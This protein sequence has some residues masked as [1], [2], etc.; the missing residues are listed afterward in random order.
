MIRNAFTMQ[1][2]K[3]KEQ[4]YQERHDALWPELKALLHAHGIRNYSI[5]L[6]AATGKLFV[7]QELLPDHTS[8][9]LKNTE[10]MQR[11]WAAMAD[12]METHPNNEPIVEPLKE[13]FTFPKDLF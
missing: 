13:V 2:K 3:G 4:V 9:Q 7:F 6:D 5:F 10:I 1:L 11:W 8:D 12:L